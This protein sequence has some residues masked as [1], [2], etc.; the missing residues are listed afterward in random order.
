M[1]IFMGYVSFR[2][3]TFFQILR[4]YIV[5][6]V[7]RIIFGPKGYLNMCFVREHKPQIWNPAERIDYELKIVIQGIVGCTPTNVLLLEIPM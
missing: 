6:E 5:C 2:E 3:G 4:L 7:S 1:G